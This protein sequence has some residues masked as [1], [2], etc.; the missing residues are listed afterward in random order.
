MDIQD[1]IVWSDES[2]LAVHKPAG[3]LA[4]QDGYNPAI[5][6]L[7]GML[8]D[9]FGKV[10]TVH[11]LDKDTSGIILFA[12]SAEAHRLLNEQF[13]QRETFKEYHA[14][15][16]G[17]PDREKMTI[18]LPLFVNGD[19]RHRTVIDHQRGKPA[20]TSISLIRSSEGFS[21]ISAFPRTG[22]THQI[23][24]H[25]A[26]AGLP[27]V[28]DPLYKSLKPLTPLQE[29]ACKQSLSL[30]IHRVALHA[31]RISFQHPLSGQMLTLE[32]P[33]PE[34]FSRAAA[35]LFQKAA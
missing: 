26:A 6:Y 31:F 8:N 15:V 9:A 24:A 25:L 3:V 10:W 27:L 17:L 13:M 33:Y 28:A 20:E 16:I 23:R 34:D 2:V 19:R 22:Y 18:S 35:Y 30:P 1:W 21:L 29:A 11:R 12:R 7:S 4:I 5:P 32:A 14:I